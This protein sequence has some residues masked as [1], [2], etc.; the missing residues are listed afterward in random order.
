MIPAT[1]RPPVLDLL[2]ER[3]RS[4][5]IDSMA[6]VVGVRRDL[7]RQG[8]LI[9]AVLV[10]SVALLTA[11][12]TLRHR[13]IQGEISKL[14]PIE[15][16]VRSLTQESGA[17]QAALSKITNTNKELATALTTVRTSSALLTDLQLR[18]PQGV[19][20]TSAVVQG[21]S[22]V[23][24]GKADDPT[25]FGRINALLLE[26]RRS[27]LLDPATVTL[28]KSERA[29]APASGERS[30]IAAAPVIFEING[31]FAMLEPKQQL[32]VLQKLRSDGMARR[33]QLLQTEGLLP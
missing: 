17:R 21:S 3:R 32:T 28:V 11:A 22:L 4:L 9:G 23:I 29:A 13:Y 1:T 27:D 18:T 10:G 20:L 26:L 14:A 33:L 30:L 25:A 12:V 19:Q 15:A 6:S 5:G 8:T 2:R 16:E 24:K 7:V 31:T